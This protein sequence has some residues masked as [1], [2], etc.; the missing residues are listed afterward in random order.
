MRTEKIELSV[1]LLSTQVSKYGLIADG[2][3]DG[4]RHAP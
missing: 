3:L 1:F 2:F 4:R